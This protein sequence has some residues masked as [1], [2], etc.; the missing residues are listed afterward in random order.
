MYLGIKE[1]ELY[2][3]FPIEGFSQKLR[4]ALTELSL[5]NNSF[6]S[7]CSSAGENNFQRL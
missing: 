4:L 7:V 3:I 2:L 6:G 5:K 1:A